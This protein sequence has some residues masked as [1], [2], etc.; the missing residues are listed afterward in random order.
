MILGAFPDPVEM[1]S[2]LEVELQSKDRI[3]LYTDGITEVFDSR[4]EMLGVEG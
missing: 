1:G 2:T 4:G 3:I